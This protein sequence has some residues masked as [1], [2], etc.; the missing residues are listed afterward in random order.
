MEL[1]ERESHLVRLEEH[2]RRAAAGHGRLVLVA[3]EAGVGKTALA[4][5]FARRGS[6]AADVMRLSFDALS[7]PGPLASVRDLAPALGLPVER[8]PAE[9]EDR[10]RFFRLMLSAF[11]SRA[12]PTVVIGEDA[13]WAD[14]A[15]LDLLRFLSRRIGDLRLLVV[16][17]YRD[18]EVGP[19]HPLRLLLGDLATSATVQ[20]LQVRPLSEEAVRTMAAGSG[21]DP[22]ALHRLTGG[23]PFFLTEVLTAE[24]EAVPATVEDAI[25]AR[26]ARL[27]PEAKAVLDVAAVIGSPIDVDLLLAVAGPVSDSIDAGIS[28]GLLRTDGD[29]VAFQHDLVREAILGAVAPP[30]RRLLHARVLAGLR[31]MPLSERDLA[32]LAHHAEAAGD[33]EATLEFA[34]AAAEQAAV[35]GAQR[36]AAAQYARALRFADRR[37]AAERARLFEGRALACYVSDQGEEAIA[38]RQSALTIWRDLGDSLRQGDNVRWLSRIHW[39]QGRGAEAEETAVAALE[40]LEPLPPGPELAMAYSNLASLRML[41]NDTEGTLWWGQQ[42][43][44]LADLLGET[45]TLVH[46]LTNVGLARFAFDPTAGEADLARSLQLA[47]GAKLHDHAARVMTNRAQTALWR[48]RLDEAERHFGAAL[49]YATDHD[50]DRSRWYLLAGRALLHVRQGEWDT[51]ENETT[52]LLQQPTIGTMTRLLALTTRA[53]V[54]V[55]RGR[56]E[57]KAALDEALALAERT[58]QLMRLGPVRAA[59]AEAAL[60][61]GDRARAQAEARAVRDLVFTRGTMWQRGEL[62]WLMWQAGAWNIPRENLAEPYNLLLAGDYERAAVVWQGIGCPYEEACALAES[63]DPALVRRAVE[64]FEALGAKPIL[65]HAIRRLRSLGVR[66]VPPI[67]RGPRASTRANPAGL[68]QREMEVLVLLA[69][70]LRNAEI[71]DRLFLTPKTVRHHVSAILGKLDVETRTEAARAASQLGITAS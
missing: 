67:R 7:T 35:L 9:G 28:G 42:A 41:D 58:G 24:D 31:E 62:A 64:T 2:L 30:R 53:Q 34:V 70:G 61:A 38:A 50:L 52:R 8:L 69:D 13:H 16:V 1:L 6:A 3:G 66:D 56:P 10:D 49:A 26:A 46:L 5:A 15:S 23:N 11:A 37:P 19:D 60:L 47:M 39:F 44:E 21:R 54:G 63:D 59:R 18:D 71:A 22:A 51:A 48:M 29:E 68:T 25:L 33:R 36:E 20:R 57:A 4:D 45:E 17:T 27:A 43:I 32:L 55:R 40:L 65:G 12:K 14:G